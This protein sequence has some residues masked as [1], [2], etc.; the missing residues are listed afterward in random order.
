M[1]DLYFICTKKIKNSTCYKT[2]AK[3][4]KEK[5]VEFLAY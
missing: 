4:L 2:V 5:Y 1:N 3:W